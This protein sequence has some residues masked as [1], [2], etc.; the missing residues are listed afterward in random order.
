LAFEEQEF[1]EG[2]VAKR[3]ADAIGTQHHEVALTEGQAN[4]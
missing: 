1:N 4:L 3:I 2:A